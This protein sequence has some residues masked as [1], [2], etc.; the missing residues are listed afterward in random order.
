MFNQENNI[1]L[2]FVYIKL[3]FRKS[4]ERTPG[5]QCEVDNEATVS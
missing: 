2:S 3:A 1:V 4:D 5:D